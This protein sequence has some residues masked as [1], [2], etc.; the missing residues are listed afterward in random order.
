MI[1]R[2]RLDTRPARAVKLAV[3]TTALA[4]CLAPQASAQTCDVPSGYATIQSAI[5]EPSCSTVDVAAGFYQ[6]PL[7]I[8]RSLTLVG[9]GATTVLRDAPLIAVGSGV[10]VVLDSLRLENGCQPESLLSSGGAFIDAISVTVA[11]SGSFGCD[12]GSSIFQDGFES[13]DLTRWSTTGSGSAG[14]TRPA[15]VAR[16]V[17]TT[18]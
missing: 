11:F 17:P 10:N 14:P 8:T 9:A 18:P 15:P 1:L 7:T 3:L 6:E 5:D 13:G 12:R 2:L 16:R 4:F